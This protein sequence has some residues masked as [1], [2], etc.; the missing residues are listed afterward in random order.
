MDTYG[1]DLVYA[2]ALDEINSQLVSSFSNEKM[3]S[4]FTYFIP[5]S[6]S[7]PSINIS[8]KFG[9]WQLVLGGQNRLIRFMIPIVSGSLGVGSKSYDLTDSQVE[10]EFQ[11]GWLGS[12]TSVNAQGS[13][14]NT[15]LQ[16]NIKLKG[17]KPGDSTDGAVT[18]VKVFPNK[19]MDFLAQGIM[20]DIMPDLFL[21]QRNLFNH[22]FASIV[23]IPQGMSDWITPKK[24]NYFYSEANGK[25]QLCVLSMVT[26]RDLPSIP[27]FDSSVFADG[28]TA[29]LILSQE[30]FMQHLLLPG[31]QSSVNRSLHLTSDSSGWKI[32]NNGGF[33]ILGS[34]GSVSNYTS[35]IV[36][37]TLRTD[38]NGGGPLK[39]LFNMDLKNAHYDWSI[40]LNNVG[41]YD[42]SIDTF[43]FNTDPNPTKHCD[44]T[45][46]WYDWALLALVEIDS[47]TS[48]NL[49]LFLQITDVLINT[50][51]DAMAK[52]VANAMTRSLQGKVSNLHLGLNWGESSTFRPSDGGLSGAFYLRGN[53]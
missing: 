6:E 34:K 52:G 45:V 9:A 33:P 30:L 21:A 51:S 3:S 23:P 48:L 4:S 12:G 36:G 27:A 1:Y 15:Q 53:V 18:T 16:F 25:G 40:Q 50:V 35:R 13:G 47:I 5:A 24:W 26:E 49:Y 32:V 41:Q 28:S 31:L 19:G 39:F 2:C 37:N 10:M 42:A 7:D 20:H 38:A 17:N 11:L 44:S 43:H 46:P 14:D 29:S 8:G 22:I